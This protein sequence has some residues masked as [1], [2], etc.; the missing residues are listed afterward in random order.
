MFTFYFKAIKNFNSYLR[1]VYDPKKTINSDNINFETLYHYNHITLNLFK[2]RN[3]EL[4]F[5]I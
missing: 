2:L 1:L 5:L 4:E 3:F